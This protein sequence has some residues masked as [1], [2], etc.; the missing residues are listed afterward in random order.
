ML[1]KQET[2]E[3]LLGGAEIHPL[4]KGTAD[5][6]GSPADLEQLIRYLVGEEVDDEP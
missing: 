3:E 2:M 6:E 5:L 1:S 4:Q